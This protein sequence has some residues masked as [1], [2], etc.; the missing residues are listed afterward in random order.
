MKKK[1]LI[2]DCFGVVASP[3]ISHWILNNL[4]PE[5]NKA[6]LLNRFDL[7]EISCDEM[8]CVFSKLACRSSDVIHQEITTYCTLDFELIDY[9]KELKATAYKIIL[10]TNANGSFLEQF[11][12][13][14]YPWFRD[15]FDSIVIS[16]EIKMV[17]P[18]KDI[19]LHSLK[20]NCLSP[21]DAIFI[22]DSSSNIL[23]AEKVGIPS[24]LFR[25]T[26]QLKADLLKYL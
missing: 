8:L 7:G 20:V 13:K 6:E 3:A 18:N 25:D 26:Q 23:G 9:I 22:D 4:G 1:A 17:K 12:C 24:I 5:F 21:E 2:F 10:L 11:I 19:Y 15:L 14:E 16:S